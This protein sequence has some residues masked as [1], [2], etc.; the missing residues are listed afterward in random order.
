GADDDAST[1]TGDSAIPDDA[2]MPDEGEGDDTV[3]DSASSDDRPHTDDGVAD[4][5]QGGDDSNAVSM[6]SGADTSETTGELTD[7][8]SAEDARDDANTTSPDDAGNEDPA[9]MQ[10]TDHEDAGF[11][12]ISEPPDD[13]S[14][15][16]SGIGGEQTDD[17]T[18]DDSRDGELLGPLNVTDASDACSCEDGQDCVFRRRNSGDEPMQWRC[19]SREI[20]CT[21]LALSCD[22]T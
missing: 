4:E 17:T 10:H 14:D 3:T 13:E 15:L 2:P 1:P 5:N 9:S 18:T 20:G 7:D 16:D 12:N 8:V 19:I 11:G 22:C 21:D 6:D